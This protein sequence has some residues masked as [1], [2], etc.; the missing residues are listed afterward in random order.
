MSTATKDLSPRI[1]VRRKPKNARYDRQSIYRAL[2]RAQLVHVS[3]VSDGQP[4]CIPTLHAR[5]G[6]RVLIHGSSAS[7][8]MRV[9]AA[10][11]P[12]CLTV[13][14]LDGLV[15][16]RSVYETGANYE[17]VML[18]GRFRPITG[19]EEK[20]DALHA[21][22]EALLPGRWAEVRPPSR[23]ELKGTAILEME[24]DEASVKTKTGGPDDDDSPDA[25]RDVWA[26]VI[27]IETTYGTAQPSP[28]LRAG[29]AVSPS[30]S[31]LTDRR[32][33]YE[34]LPTDPVDHTTTSE[35]R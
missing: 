17:S 14:T 33:S 24:I 8:M 15:L 16:A 21:F 25:R 7:R 34:P 19:D 18:L 30:V 32:L 4:Y 27:P 12:A 23:Q 22:V 26:G 13:T 6:N 28:G 10:G 11:A 29:I 5:V 3:F 31:R 9:L 1:R 35:R 2:E 20:L